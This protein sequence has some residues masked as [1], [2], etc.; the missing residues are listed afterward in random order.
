VVRSLPAWSSVVKASLA[1]HAWL[2]LV[3]GGLM[4]L[5][6]LSGTLAVFYQELERWEQPRALEGQRAEPD[7]VQRAVASALARLPA[8][9]PHLYVGLPAASMPRLTV[10]TDKEHEAWFVNADGSL[11]ERVA[12]PWTHLLLNLHI[13]L[14][15][16]STVGLLVVGASGALLFGLIVSGFL[17]HPRIVK[18]AF[19]LRLGS[20]HLEQTDIHNRLSV[21]G[22]PFHVVIALTGAYFGLAS[23]MFVLLGWAFH[24][25]KTDEA[26]DVIYGAEPKVH[27]AAGAPDVAT[28]L[29]RLAGVTPAG[30][31]P[32]F[33]T[34]HDAGTPRQFVAFEVRQPG[35]LIWAEYYQFDG[36]GT[37]LGRTDYSDGPVGRQVIYSS[38]RIHFGNFGGWPVKVLYGLLGLSLTVISASGINIWL[39][40]RRT[41]D[42]LND[43]WM[44]TI[45]GAPAA[46]ALTAVTTVVFGVPSTALFWVALASAIGWSLFAR[47]PEHARRVLCGITAALLG[48]LVAGYTAT[49]GIAGLT[50]AASWITGGVLGAT[51]ILA[52][53]AARPVAAAVSEG[54]RTHLT[55]VI[56]PDPVSER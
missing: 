54:A 26:T 19:R 24:G 14:H 4:Y 9:P 40:R 47:Q 13:Y 15:L 49:F 37:Y 5:I 3:A 45:W 41:R 56:P 35:R 38:Y 21:W 28:A 55:G 30:T 43:L 18:D 6:C 32:S 29:R 48:A 53:V 10:S 31:S 44:G 50:P 23:V 33:L 27:G 52:T 39:A 12:H 1:G 22:A 42:Y 17:A 7:V 2:G 20:P 25:G 51:A 8:A 11:G 36:A 16:P 34:V 46:L